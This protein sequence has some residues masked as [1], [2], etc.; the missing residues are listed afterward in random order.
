[1]APTSQPSWAAAAA[2]VGAGSGSSLI[3][4]VASWARST[5]P[6][7]STLGCIPVL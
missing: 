1:M 5:L 7:F 2:A 6:T 3:A 4:P